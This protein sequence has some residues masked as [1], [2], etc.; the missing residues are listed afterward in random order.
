MI[1]RFFVAVVWTTSLSLA[2]GTQ[3]PSGPAAVT[4]VPTAASQACVAGET[5]LG[6]TAIPPQAP[7]GTF[8]EANVFCGSVTVAGR[9]APDRT[10]VEAVVDGRVCDRATVQ[11]GR[12]VLTVPLGVCPPENEGGGL[13]AGAVVVFRVDGEDAAQ[14]ARLVAPV[15]VHQIDLS[16]R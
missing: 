9:P 10:I 14:R 16:V 11:N 15:F 6:G 12:Y 7:G 2:C 1:L 8:V 3:A 5:F 4:Y 13:S